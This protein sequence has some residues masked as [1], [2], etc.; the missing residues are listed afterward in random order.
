M[1]FLCTPHDLQLSILVDDIVEN[2][3]TEGIKEE[4]WNCFLFY[5]CILWVLNGLSSVQL[6]LYSFEKL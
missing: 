1:K 3:N 2:Q 6:I 5:E 4:F